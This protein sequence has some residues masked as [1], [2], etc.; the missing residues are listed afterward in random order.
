[1]MPEHH[2]TDARPFGVGMGTIPLNTM[3]LIGASYSPWQTWNGQN[4]SQWAQALLPLE[5]P[6]EH[7]GNRTRYAHIIAENYAADY[8][9]LFG[10]LPDLADKQRFPRNAGP[11]DNAAA[12]IAWETMT[13]E[14]RDEVNRIFANIGKALAAYERTLLP[15][16]A[17]FDQYVTALDES[18]RPQGESILTDDEIAGLRIFLDKGQCIDCHNGPRFTND[19]FHNTAVP[20]APGFPLKRGRIEGVMRVQADIFNCLGSYSDAAP[21]ECAELR[22]LVTEGDALLGSMKTPT[23][24]NVTETAPYMHTG[25]FATLADVVE[26]YNGGGY[27]LQGHNELE[28]LGLTAEETRQLEAFLYTLT[29]IER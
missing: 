24:R 20:G 8:E 19:A 9:A 18:E 2:F 17:R 14:D 16:P 25:Q 23:L 27:T 11:V 13:P 4:D 21:E 7:G 1:H 26:H 5:N 10:P 29:E 15:K 28:P 6:L 22:F 3:T 12:S